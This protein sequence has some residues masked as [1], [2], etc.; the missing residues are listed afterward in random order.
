MVGYAKSFDS[1]KTVS[2]KVSDKKLYKKIRQN[3]GRN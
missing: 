3:V 2:F 1:N